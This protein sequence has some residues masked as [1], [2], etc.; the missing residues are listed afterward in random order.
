[1]IGMRG[2]KGAKNASWKQYHRHASG[3]TDALTTLG[4]RPKE[5][6][7]LV[8]ASSCGPAP[9]QRIISIMTS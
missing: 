5:S 8:E 7:S 4:R 2:E 6:W 9:T 3:R 1:M